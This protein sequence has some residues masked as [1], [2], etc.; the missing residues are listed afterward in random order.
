MNGLYKTNKKE[1]PPPRNQ[2]VDSVVRFFASGFYSGYVPVIP[3][4][5]GAA[6]GVLVYQVPRA[7]K[8]RSAVSA[9]CSR[10][11]ATREGS[12]TGVAIVRMPD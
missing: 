3:G 6:L 8:S 12:L 10:R 9:I 11:A 1:A 2:F 4:T 5:T 7:R